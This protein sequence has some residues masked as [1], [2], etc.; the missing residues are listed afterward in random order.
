MS[1]DVCG[2]RKGS[3]WQRRKSGWGSG[4]YRDPASGWIGGLCA[5]FAQ[6]WGVPRALVRVA[7]VFLF[8]ITG[9][10]AF[11][12]YLVGLV[13]VAPQPNRWRDREASQSSCRQSDEHG[14]TG[15]CA[16]RGQA[17]VTTDR[18]RR[19]QERLDAALGR[20]EA[21]ERQVTSRRYALN[22]E[23]SRL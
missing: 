14:D 1:N 10:M 16:D 2:S 4:L 13:L 12:A 18:L 15:F 20:V 23:F 21:M 19:A 7:A 5:G 8:F 17:G 3:F 9:T 6:H 22:R 11:W